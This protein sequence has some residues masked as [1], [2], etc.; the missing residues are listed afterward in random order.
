MDDYNF[1]VKSNK[2]KNM[3]RN[4]KHVSVVTVSKLINLTD[5]YLRIAATD[6]SSRNSVT[7]YVYA[8]SL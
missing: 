2:N 8:L 7:P 6:K 3:W 5:T 1:I 4:T